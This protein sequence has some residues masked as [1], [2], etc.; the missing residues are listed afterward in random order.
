MK[1]YFKIPDKCPFCGVKTFIQDDFLY[2]SNP[3][4]CMKFINLLKHFTGKKGLDIKG[5]SEATLQ[6]LMD[7]GWLN[8]YQ[9]LFNLANFRDEW[10][11]KAGFGPKSVD[12]ILN[13]IENAKNCELWQ[14][15]SALS[16]PLIGVTFSKEIAKHEK[17]WDNFIQHI[18]ENYDFTQWSNFG[19]EMY[20]ALHN[21]DYK[22]AN[23]LAHQILNLKNSLVN[24]STAN[25][26]IN[27]LSG[28]IFCIT[29]KLEHFQNRDELI[30]FIEDKG[31]KVT[32]SVS[33]KTNYLVN[34]DVNSTSSKN[35][36]A[37]Q[38]GIP[39]ISE[40]QLLEIIKK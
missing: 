18:E 6:K 21:F 29:G 27:T 13:A 11:T 10:I 34:N 16:I 1:N 40:V 22:E 28:L 8:N 39:I 15:I 4:C 33:K 3:N 5:L 17:T 36:K 31:G 37:Q 2:C 25:T 35:I 19:Y 30:S 32:S 23:I 24:T 14:F 26:N 38:L 20:A 12:N 7:W 9:E